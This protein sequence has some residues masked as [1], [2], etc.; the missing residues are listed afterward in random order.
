MFETVL[1]KYDPADIQNP[2]AM[3]AFDNVYEQ[4]HN[5]VVVKL[6][7]ISKTPVITEDFP[8]NKKTI[9]YK[10]DD[11]TA[12]T[13]NLGYDSNY[14]YWFEI[15]VGMG[16]NSTVFKLNIRYGTNL[17]QEE[18]SFSYREDYFHMKQG[19]PLNGFPASINGTYNILASS[20]I[21]RMQ[22]YDKIVA[23]NTGS[24]G[25]LSFFSGITNGARCYLLNS[26]NA[27][28]YVSSPKNEAKYGNNDITYMKAQ[29]KASNNEIFTSDSIYTIL[30]PSNFYE[31][32]FYS[33]VDG[34]DYYINKS[35][36]TMM[37]RI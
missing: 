16:K 28:T 8:N 29:F 26:G 27:I 5:K 30:A 36:Q 33:D 24:N 15:Y 10:I 1:L 3:K 25:T 14:G 23:I 13:V 2:T 22:P 32:N 17:I 20:G 11:I 7:L 6:P 37:L 34:N 31:T 12:I 18:L 21:F 9:S 35:D 19:S 4:F